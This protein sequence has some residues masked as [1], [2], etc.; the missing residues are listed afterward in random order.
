[1][2][3][4]D[5]PSDV[6]WRY[7]ETFDDFDSILGWIAFHPSKLECFVDD[8]RVRPQLG[9]YYGGWITHELVGPFKGDPECEEV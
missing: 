4:L 8:E 5:G 1:L 6:A 9:G 3:L 2:D 7:T